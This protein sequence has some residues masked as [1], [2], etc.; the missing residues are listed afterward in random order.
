MV[1]KGLPEYMA[2]LL[3]LW[4]VTGNGKTIWRASLEDAHTGECRKFA[5]LEDLFTY[6]EAQTDA[7]SNIRAKGDD[8]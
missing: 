4:P 8:K 2:Y 7:K 3:R 6:L 5:S 1:S